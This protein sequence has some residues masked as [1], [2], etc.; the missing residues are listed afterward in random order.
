MSA[1]QVLRCALIKQMHQFS[2]QKLAFY[3][4]DSQSFQAFCRLPFGFTPRKSILQEDISRIQPGTWERINRQLVRWANEQGLERGQKIRV[5]STAVPT[6]IHYPLDSRLLLDGIRVINRCLK[7]LRPYA[8]FPFADHERRAQRRCRNITHCRGQK[9]RRKFYRDLLKVARKTLRY[10]HVASEKE[11]LYRRPPCRPHLQ[12]LAHYAQLLARVMEQTERR[13]LDGESVPAQ[14]EIVS[15]FEEH[16]D[17]I[18]EGGREDVF[19]TSCGSPA[20]NPL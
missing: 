16:S 13:I 18:R 6:D 17:I 7:A 14:E 4:A 5:D 3:L 1:E 10:A 2:Y 19:D 11:D 20:R 15:I 12:R 9:R 8:E